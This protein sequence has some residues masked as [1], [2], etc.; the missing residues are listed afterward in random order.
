M[1]GSAEIR[2]KIEKYCAYQERSHLEVKR[3]LLS[4][5]LKSGDADMLMTDLIRNNFLNEERFAKAFALGK[6]RQK[7]WG[8]RKIKTA[9]KSKGVSDPLIAKAVMGIDK[10][11]YEQSLQELL[12]KKAKTLRETDAVKRRLKLQNFLLTKGY[13]TEMVID[14]VKAFTAKG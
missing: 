5:G 14:A 8:L 12:E 2:N 13:E 1:T 9:L 11:H 3:K 6:F 4:L 10:N 7:K